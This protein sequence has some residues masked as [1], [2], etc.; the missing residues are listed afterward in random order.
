MN[1]LQHDNKVSE[2]N[3]QK[4]QIILDYNKIK[5]AVDTFDQR[6]GIYSCKRKSNATYTRDK[7][8]V[9]M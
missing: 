6:V 2:S 7:K 9:T 8:L 1:T 5:D 4:H 3:A